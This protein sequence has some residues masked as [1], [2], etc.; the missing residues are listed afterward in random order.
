MWC[1][2]Y[3]HDQ[4]L[5]DTSEKNGIIAS[6]FSQGS[7]SVAHWTLEVIEGQEI[8]EMTEMVVKGHLSVHKLS[9]IAEQVAAAN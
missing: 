2:G 4:D 6:Y 7:K 1:W 5:W 8:I 9:R 3:F